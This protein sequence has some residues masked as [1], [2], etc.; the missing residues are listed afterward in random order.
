MK[1]DKQIRNGYVGAYYDWETDKVVVWERDEQGR[2]AKTFKAPKYF[3]V[4]DENGEYVS[5]YK[6]K[7]I[8]LDFDNQ[9]EFKAALNQYRNKFESDIPPLFKVLMDEYYDSKPS[10]VHYALLDIEWYTEA[11]R[12]WS[13]TKNPY[14]AITAVCIWQSWTQRYKLYAVPPP[15]LEFKK[16]KNEKPF[17]REFPFTRKS[18]SKI[19]Q[20]QKY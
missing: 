6:D 12:G 13:S 16:L 2:T 19:L 3:Y 8:R 11:S 7:L 14:G 4:P 18:I 17:F 10:K 20:R 1:K 9:G 15:T 5:I